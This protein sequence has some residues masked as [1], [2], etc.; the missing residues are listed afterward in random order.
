MWYPFKRGW[1]QARALGVLQVYYEQPLK[2]PL[3]DFEARLLRGAVN[4]TMKDG[5]SPHDAASRF[6]AALG[7][8]TVGRGGDLM[9]IK[10]PT[11][12]GRMLALKGEMKHWDEHMAA[13]K[14]VS[15]LEKDR[16]QA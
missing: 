1:F 11:F 6:M 8:T 7:E 12:L 3:P 14:Q 10:W 13:V 2:N 9:D 4:L 15:Q 5:G 16:Q